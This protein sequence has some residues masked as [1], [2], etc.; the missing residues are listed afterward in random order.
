MS[1]YAPNNKICIH[2]GSLLVNSFS[3]GLMK[4]ETHHNAVEHRC[5][6]TVGGLM[7]NIPGKPVY[8]YIGNLAAR[9]INLPKVMIVGFASRGPTCIM[10]A[11]DN[12]Q[13]C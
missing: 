2:S 12:E 6:M 7:D 8:I 1:Y 5:S 4:I 3:V 13:P 11:R 10:Y 9:S